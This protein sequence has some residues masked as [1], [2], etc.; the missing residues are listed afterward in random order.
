MKTRTIQKNKIS[1][2]K[3]NNSTP[4][5][6]KQF[7]P[8]S[9]KSYIDFL[10]QTIGN[11]AVGRMIQAKFKIG[12]PGDKYEQE[13]DRVA[14]R[15][16]CMSNADVA[17]QVETGRIQRPCL[18]CE[19]EQALQRQ[20]I[21]EEEEQSQA[22]GDP[23]ENRTRMPDQLR[24]GLEHLSGIDLSGV[25]VH[26]NSA[27]PA[28]LNA[29]SYTQGQEIH[30]GPGQEQHLPH[31]GWHAVQQMRGR[32]KPTMQVKGV[33]I[34]DDAALE[35]EAD[36]MGAKAMRMPVESTLSQN[37]LAAL[38]RKRSACEGGEGNCPKCADGAIPAQDAVVLQRQPYTYTFVSRSSYGFT[39]PGFTRP[40]CA[41]RSLVAGSAAPSIT[42][43][44]SG[45]YR[46]RRNDG[47][48][49]TATCTRLAAGLAATRA[50]E[51]SHAAGAR[52]G[53]A[54]ANTA[55]GLPKSFA[56]PLLC[57]AALPAVRTAWN[58]P[59]NAAW[60]NEVAHGP[61]TSPP[62]GQTFTPENAAGRCTFT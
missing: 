46:V 3:T 33:S 40:S 2:A 13:A 44:A 36:V 12:Q 32:V 16:M 54:A 21:E 56:T 51:N 1:E 7:F 11:H 38:Q 4:K 31:E 30:V 8:S 41:G 35:R 53:V 15:V 19:E 17:Q 39:T 45:T 61:G 62:T 60:A 42:V 50:H 43:H 22:S 20:P 28:Q 49:K 34:N 59:V 27:K 6:P 23:L 47:V 18:E 55:Q 48:L 9:T 10:H 26:T 29:L 14:D 5:G 24:A 25:R 52:A 58:T 57:A 37:A